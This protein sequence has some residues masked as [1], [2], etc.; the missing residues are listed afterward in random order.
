M[1]EQNIFMNSATEADLHI[2][3]RKEK[4]VGRLETAF[5]RVTTLKINSKLVIGEKLSLFGVR[6]PQA[7]TALLALVSPTMKLKEIEAMKSDTRV[8]CGEMGL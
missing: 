8:E 5:K 7:G 1:E 2:V 6:Q 3:E 4:S